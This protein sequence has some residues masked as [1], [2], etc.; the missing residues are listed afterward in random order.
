MNELNY[1]DR[2]SDLIKKLLNVIYV[3]AYKVKV[4]I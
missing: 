3:E 4:F 2:I 1:G